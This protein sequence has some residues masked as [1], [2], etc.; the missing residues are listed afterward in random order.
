MHLTLYSLR[1]QANAYA[2]QATHGFGWAT[3]KTKMPALAKDSGCKLCLPF[4]KPLPPDLQG[5]K[6]AFS[7]PL[8]LLFLVSRPQLAE[9]HLVMLPALGRGSS[10]HCRGQ[11]LGCQEPPSWAQGP[12][13]S[14][15]SG[16]SGGS[17]VKL[18]HAPDPPPLRSVMMV[19]S[20]LKSLR[21]T[22]NHVTGMEWSQQLHKKALNPARMKEMNVE[23]KYPFTYPCSKLLAM[24]QNG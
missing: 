22:R 16:F 5:R 4:S 11:R 1:A 15:F 7:H 9:L 21:V 14:P 12:E 8:S 24:I 17:N 20:G 2:L 23:A 3:P 10:E 13:Q 19:T 18:N 6:A